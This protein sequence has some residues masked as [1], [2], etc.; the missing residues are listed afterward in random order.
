MRGEFA[1]IA[2]I[3]LFEVEGFS[4]DLE[5]RRTEGDAPP[6]VDAFEP[7][8]AVSEKKGLTSPVSDETDPSLRMEGGKKSKGGFRPSGA[9]IPE[10]FS[11]TSPL[12]AQQFS[13]WNDF[14]LDVDVGR[15]CTDKCSS[16]VG[17]GNSGKS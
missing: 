10:E 6:L 11:C 13:D 17:E 3:E 7:D 14:L 16:A 5:Q 4:S 8:P 9:S 1:N 12:P 2:S 15:K